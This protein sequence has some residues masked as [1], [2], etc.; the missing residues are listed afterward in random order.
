VGN[1]SAGPFAG[2]TAEW[3]D[4]QRALTEDYYNA[5]ANDLDVNEVTAGLRLWDFGFQLQPE[6]V[7][8][9]IWLDVNRDIEGCSDSCAPPNCVRDWDVRL[10][11]ELTPRP[12]STPGG[13]AT[14]TPVLDFVPT[15]RDVGANGAHLC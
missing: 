12:T 11:R 13:G 14:P 5:R 10:A 9:K 6:S 3:S 1:F 4:P 2:G 7:I 15:L 8:E